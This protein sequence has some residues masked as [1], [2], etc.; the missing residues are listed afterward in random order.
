MGLVA[1]ALGIG[2]VA[3][4]AAFVHIIA[5]TFLKS[6]LFF[7]VRQVRNTFD[8]YEISKM[9]GYIRHYS[10]G[11]LVLMLGTL[12]IV[13]FPP[14]GLFVS[15][16]AIFKTMLAQER[17]ALFVV[18]VLV[19]LCCV[20]AIVQKLLSILYAKETVKPTGYKLSMS[21]TAVQYLLVGFA[22]YVFFFKDG[23]V[24]NLINEAIK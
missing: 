7:Q 9:G 24:M 4:Y 22:F 13:A 18:L 1:I 17:W 12:G 23:F 15:E 10:A 8:T 11:A 6:A 2:G 20:Y 21:L 16:L 19:L 5:H 3:R 14:S